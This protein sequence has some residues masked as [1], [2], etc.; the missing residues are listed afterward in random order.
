VEEAE[1]V[2][3][4]LTALLWG[5]LDP[6]AKKTPVQGAAPSQ[7]LERASATFRANPRFRAYVLTRQ[8]SFDS[9]SMVR[10]TPELLGDS[11]RLAYCP[12]HASRRALPWSLHDGP[13]DTARCTQRADITSKVLAILDGMPVL[14]V[15]YCGELRALCIQKTSKE[16]KGGASKSELG[17]TPRGQLTQIWVVHRLTKGRIL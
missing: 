15:F 10:I 13:T 16:E 8:Q 2:P 4:R 6:G 3:P 14:L 1:G 5:A 9:P 12:Y 11:E 7:W 17:G